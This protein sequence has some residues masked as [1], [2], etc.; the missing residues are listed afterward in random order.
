MPKRTCASGLIPPIAS[1][2]CTPPRVIFGVHIGTLQQESHHWHIIIG[3]VAHWREELLYRIHE[4]IWALRSLN[5][6]TRRARMHRP[7]EPEKVI[8]TV[9]RAEQGER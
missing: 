2:L 5:P 9:R 7:H 4:A 6:R 1:A 8:L 3:W